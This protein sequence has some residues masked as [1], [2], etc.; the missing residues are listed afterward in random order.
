LLTDRLF[1]RSENGEYCRGITIEP[2]GKAV[3]TILFIHGTGNDLIYPS[4]S[5]YKHLFMQNIRVCAFDL[6]GHGYQGTTLYSQKGVQNF[7]AWAVQQ[8]SEVSTDPIFIIGHSLGGSLALA[9]A[10]KAGEKLA[11]LIL[12]STPITLAAS[13]FSLIRELTSFIRSSVWQE[14]KIYGSWDLLPAIGAFKRDIYPIRLENPKVNYVTQVDAT[15]KSLNLI[16]ELDSISNRVLL[17]YGTGDFIVNKTDATL[18]R[19]RVEKSELVLIDGATHFSTILEAEVPEK[20][21]SFIKA[22][23]K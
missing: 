9:Y 20:I 4:I 21:S 10:A 8:T 13:V 11:G 19:D 3:A 12:I 6:D 2:P 17:I 18:I 15:I 22:N 14:K 7:V 23:I 16:N 1:L 5:L